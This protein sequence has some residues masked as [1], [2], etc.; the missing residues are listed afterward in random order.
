MVETT[1]TTSVT[2]AYDLL[3]LLPPRHHSYRSGGGECVSSNDSCMRLDS[4]FPG[5]S[6]RL[7]GLTYIIREF[8]GNKAWCEREDGVI[9]PLSGHHETDT[10]ERSSFRRWF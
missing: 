7:D 5:A 9:V 2:L 10:W 3:R 1:N 4:L 8:R 6:F